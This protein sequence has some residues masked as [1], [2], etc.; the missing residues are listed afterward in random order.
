MTGTDNDSGRDSTALVSV[1]L[2][3]RSYPIHIGPGLLDAA[4]ICSRPHMRGNQ[5]AVISNDVVAPL[6]LDRLRH[7]LAARK[8]QVD[9][10]PAAG[11]R[12]IQESGDYASDGLSC[13]SIAT[14]APP[15]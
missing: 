8:L 11:R 7:A 2:G 10:F 9:V 6:Y 14:T 13:C 5:V 12:A 4:A 1:A 15:R 3:E